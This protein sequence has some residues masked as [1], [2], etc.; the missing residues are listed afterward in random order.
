MAGIDLLTDGRIR[1]A[2]PRPLPYKLRDGAG[3]Y[4]LITP[5]GAK[6]WRLR[7][8]AGGRESMLSLGT[9]PATSLK[10]AR[11]RR[12]ELRSALEAGRNPS[13]ERRAAR[14]HSANTFEAIAGEWLDKQPFAPKT[15]EK[16]NW[17]F[18]DVL[19][20]Y[21]GSRPITALTP[22]ELL[23][24]FRRLERRGKIETAHRIKQRVGQVTRYAIATGRAVRDPT[25]DLRGALA[26]HSRPLQC[27]KRPYRISC[28][29]TCA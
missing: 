26:P 2:R 11:A 5:G 8:A 20:P 16:A 29:P 27:A 17:M 12:A 18:E 7:Y 23:E 3:L 10:A 9:Y 15:R 22:P 6:Q 19:F 1:A 13:L 24:V 14:T 25:A 28:L 21:I 4:L